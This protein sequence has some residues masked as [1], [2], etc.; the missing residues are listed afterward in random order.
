MKLSTI[1]IAEVRSNTKTGIIQIKM[2]RGP[3]HILE[4]E[5]AA[6]F[7]KL[8]DAYI[9]DNNSHSVASLLAAQNIID[10]K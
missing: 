5:K 4:G 9:C 6:Q 1:K 2:N 8:R 10:L 3:D 7:E